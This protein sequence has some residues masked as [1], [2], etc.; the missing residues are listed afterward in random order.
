MVLNFSFEHEVLGESAA[1]LVTSCQLLVSCASGNFVKA[2]RW[3]F[4]MHRKQAAGN[5]VKANAWKFLRLKSSGAHY[6]L[7]AYMSTLV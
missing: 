4:L 5:L 3:T 6:V 7:N 2:N 1:P